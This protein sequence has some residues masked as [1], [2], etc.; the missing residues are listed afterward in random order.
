M[1]ISIGCIAQHLSGAN[2]HSHLPYRSPLGV[3]HAQRSQSGASV[4][5]GN[6]EYGTDTIQAPF[7]TEDEPGQSALPP[8]LEMTPLIISGPSSNRVD[9][10]FFSD[11]CEQVWLNIWNGSQKT[12]FMYTDL[13]SEQDKFFADALRLAE[14][15]TQ[16][17]TFHPVQPT[18]NFWAAFSPSKEV[19]WSNRSFWDINDTVTCLPNLRVV[20]ALVVFP[21][22]RLCIG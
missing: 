8:S 4:S 3:Q 12:P 11:G 14:D 2:A 13:A 16:K 10:V 20:S 22:S 5:L 1:N 21:K 9:F 18:M 17:H 19:S 6:V 15:V 7:M